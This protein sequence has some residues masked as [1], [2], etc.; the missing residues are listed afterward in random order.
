MASTRVCHPFSTP[1]T[2]SPARK[3]HEKVKVMYPN[4][5]MPDLSHKSLTDPSKK[6]SD[7]VLATR[8]RNHKWEPS[9]YCY[10]PGEREV[11]TEAVEEMDPFFSSLEGTIDY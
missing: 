6:F 10:A 3:T 4:L 8:M 11:G 2:V 1:L 7:E 5:F 9:N